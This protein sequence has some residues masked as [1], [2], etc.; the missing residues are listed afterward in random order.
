M[1]DPQAKKKFLVESSGKS[2]SVDIST[3]KGQI[4]L[5]FIA[6]W[7]MDKRMGQRRPSFESRAQN[8]LGGYKVY[9]PVKCQNQN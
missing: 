7:T 3:E 2:F 9:S 4:A 8:C 1:Q 6:N 5:E